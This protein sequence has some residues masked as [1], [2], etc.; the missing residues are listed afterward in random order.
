V[1]LEF[2]L[3]L[4]KSSNGERNERAKSDKFIESAAKLYPVAKLNINNSSLVSG[5][6]SFDGNLIEKL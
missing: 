6:V 3:K 4:I 2:P 5:R 1:K